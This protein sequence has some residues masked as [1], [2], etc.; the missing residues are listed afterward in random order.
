MTKEDHAYIPQFAAGAMEN[1]GLITYRDNAILWDP[2]INTIAQLQR[3]AFVMAHELA[4]QW[5]GNIVTCAQEHIAHMRSPPSPTPLHH[6]SV[7]PLPCL[8]CAGG[9]RSSGSTSERHAHHMPHTRS[10]LPPTPFSVLT[11]APHSPLLCVQ[12]LCSLHAV[13]R[14]GRSQSGAAAD[15]AVHHRRAEAGAHH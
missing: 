2:A 15:R 13:P 7:S 14:R 3:V 1:W 5:F 10:H 12:G 9:G 6:A 8:C 11:L 4:H